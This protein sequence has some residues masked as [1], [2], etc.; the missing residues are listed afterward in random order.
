MKKIFLA[1]MA[2]IISGCSSTTNLYAERLEYK[3]QADG[4]VERKIAFTDG[5]SVIHFWDNQKQDKPIVLL[6]HG[7]G[8]DAISNWQNA[9]HVLAQNYHV[10]VPDILWYGQS[11]SNLPANL[12]SQILAMTQFL[13]LAAPNQKV[14]VVG[15]SY[16]GF[17]TYGLMAKTDKVKSATIISSPGGSFDAQDLNT[18]L[19]GFGVEKPSELFVPRN[20][21]EFKRLI[22]ASSFLNVDLV[23]AISFDGVYEHYFTGNAEQKSIML[24]HLI[25]SR[26]ELVSKIAVKKAQQQLP[27]I[28]LIWGEDDRIFPLDSGMRLSK[29]LSAPL[30]IVT[31]SAHNILLEKPGTVSRLLTEFLVMNQ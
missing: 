4:F 27:P 25:E 9:M 14:N 13:E 24:D 28:Q 6:L 7:V 18:M 11:T 15:H 19:A 29:E 22:N 16:G 26:D 1:L 12:D 5:S 2:L 21:K 17:I 10:L 3:A 23:P 31:D 20:D 30:Y 8:G